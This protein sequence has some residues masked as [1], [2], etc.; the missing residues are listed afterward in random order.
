LKAVVREPQIAGQARYSDAQCRRDI[1]YLQSIIEA[2][3]RPGFWP[4]LEKQHPLSHAQLTT[5]FFDNV[6]RTWATPESKAVID[7][8]FAGLSCALAMFDLTEPGG[9]GK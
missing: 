1:H 7:G 4:W 3:C 6:N 8:F 5:M 2:V 9:N